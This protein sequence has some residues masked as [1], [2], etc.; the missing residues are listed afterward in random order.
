MKRYKL[1]RPARIKEA[2]TD[3]TIAVLTFVSGSALWAVVLTALWGWFVVPLGVQSIGAAEAIGLSAVVGMFKRPP[4]PELEGNLGERCLRA[5]AAS[6]VNSLSL[7][8]M[9]GVAHLFV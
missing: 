3:G 1:W 7:L 8:V 2:I 4:D 5:F 9:G 6:V